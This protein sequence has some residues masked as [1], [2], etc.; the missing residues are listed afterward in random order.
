MYA[1]IN[2]CRSSLLCGTGSAVQ[3][4]SRV[5]VVSP[6]STQRNNTRMPKAGQ[7]AV[8]KPAAILRLML[9]PIIGQRSCVAALDRRSHPKATEVSL[10]S[11]QR[12]EDQYPTKS[13]PKLCQQGTLLLVFAGFRRRCRTWLHHV[14]LWAQVVRSKKP[15]LA[16]ALGA[17]GWSHWVWLGW[18]T[19]RQT[20]L[21][22]F[23]RTRATR[24]PREK[25]RGPP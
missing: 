14:A 17:P 6:Q 11:Q 12:P 20:R 10:G 1:G 18:S 16:P 4:T 7:S 23:A 5:K 3:H 22:K 15:S 25:N 13:T 19:L 9:F 2:T 8:V 24:E 21:L